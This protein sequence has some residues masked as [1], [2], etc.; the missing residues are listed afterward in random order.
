MEA[1][2][3]ALAQAA[4]NRISMAYRP[5]TRSAHT[6][7]LKTYLSFVIVMDLPL[8]FTV[9]STLS[10]LEYLHINN[11]SHRVML[12]YVSS[13]KALA[14]R[15]DWDQK[16]LS[17]QLVTSYLKSVARNSGFNPT[18]RGIFSLPILSAISKACDLLS[19]PPL[20]RAAFLLAFFAFLRMSN[21][22]PHSKA[23]FSPIKHILRQD[24]LFL[25]PGAHILLKWTKTLQDTSAHHFVQ[26]PRLENPDLCPVQALKE[27]MLTRPL[28]KHAPLFVH[29]F[30]PFH[31]VIDTTIR[32]ALKTVLNYLNIPLQGHGFHS[33]RRSGATLAF[34]SNIQ[35]QDIMAHGLWKSAAV[36][37][38][39]QQASIAPS[40]VPSTFAS[41]IPPSL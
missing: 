39:L 8:Q 13:L 3:S 17:H 12:N 11:I 6:T 2:S 26:I 32:D 31:P 20:F 5:A 10:F 35:L 19:D 27:L 36:W 30:P 23:L 25:D 4:W 38:Y 14:K 16:P 41:I 9:H 22:A 21:I 7:H 1:P 34:D 40:I 29:K 15:Y 28:P 33:F 24:I 37:Q 18:A